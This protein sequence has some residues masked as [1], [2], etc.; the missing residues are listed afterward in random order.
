MNR[1]AASSLGKSPFI[2]A[3]LGKDA[4]QVAK[5]GVPTTEKDTSM[6]QKY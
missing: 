6:T 5:S 4:E 3:S 2:T 1:G